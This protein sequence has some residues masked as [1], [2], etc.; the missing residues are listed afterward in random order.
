MSGLSIQT[1]IDFQYAHLHAWWSSS[2]QGD[3]LVE[4]AAA[5]T[6]ENFV[7]LL[8]N[9]C[10]IVVAEASRLQ[11]QL[12]V[13]QYE[14]LERL[15]KQLDAAGRE[16]VRAR[17]QTLMAENFKV[18]LNYRFFPERV[19]ALQDMLIPFPDPVVRKE[20]LEMMLDAADTAQFIR[21]LPEFPHRGEMAEIIRQ[22]DA[23][24][25]IMRAECAIDNLTFQNELATASKLGG[26][27]AELATR[28]TREEIDL[29]NAL[30]LLRNANFYHLEAPRLEAAW[31]QGGSRLAAEAWK[32]LAEARDTVTVLTELPPELT[33]RLKL[34]ANEPLD[35]L[36]N[37]LHGRLYHDA[38]H[39]FYDAGRPELA[40]PAYVWLLRYET[41]N[42]GR[43][44]EGLRFGLSRR[45]IEGMLIC[46]RMEKCA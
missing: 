33:L 17:C 29:T 19:G 30:T 35:Q 42:L 24:K 37:R 45:A 40:M 39:C 20:R 1:G 46:Q 43:I 34:S 21:M 25:D 22:L 44:Y 2:A 27:R 6:P 14:R 32:R 8:Q 23:D 36:E 3:A 5:A 18:L 9:R 31:L 11:S 38:L 12:M 15:E 26:A 10:G 4:L 13:R 41:V 28:L 16:Y 7:H